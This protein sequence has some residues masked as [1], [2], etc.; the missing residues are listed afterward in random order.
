MKKNILS[1]LLVLCLGLSVSLGGISYAADDSCDSCQAITS[2]DMKTYDKSPGYDDTYFTYYNDITGYKSNGL[3]GFYSKN[4]RD[5]NIPPMYDDIE[6]LDSNYIKVKRGG[7]WGIIS[8]NG[9]QLINTFY[10]NIEIFG[11]Y[12]SGKFRVRLNGKYGII[13][14]NNNAIVPPLYQSIYR[15]ND[16]YI[17]VEKDSK[18]GIISMYNGKITVSISYDDVNYLNPYFKIKFGGKWGLID[19]LQN[20]IV[21]AKYDDIKILN[22]NYFIV[23]NYNVWGTVDKN[24][25]EEVISPKYDKIEVGKANYLKVKHGG[26]WGAVTN[27]GEIVIPINKGPFEINRELKKIY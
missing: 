24:T 4:N 25:G 16:E 20:S 15:I 10:D 14:E 13:D 11:G 21:P 1:I 12:M 26:K 19:K 2:P 17:K 6:A 9:Y 7:K 8:T 27:N 23:K 3:W 5:I 18:Y 22:N